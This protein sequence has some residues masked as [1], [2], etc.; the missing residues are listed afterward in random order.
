M[1]YNSMPHS[2]PHVKHITISHLLLTSCLPTHQR[3]MA[4][5]TFSVC[6][7]CAKLRHSQDRLPTRERPG[8]SRRV[9][10]SA[11]LLLSRGSATQNAWNRLPNSDIRH[12]DK[13]NNK[14]A[15]DTR[16][17]YSAW[18]LYMQTATHDTNISHRH[19]SYFY[20]RINVSYKIRRHVCDLSPYK[21]SFA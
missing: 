1:H 4:Y 6:D 11:C 21:I 7:I 12:P 2:L 17:M 8:P 3:A 10:P 19:L 18:R 16:A 15:F 20:M 14:S 13:W 9:N 5:S